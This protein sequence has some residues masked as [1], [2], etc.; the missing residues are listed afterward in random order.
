VKCEKSEKCE[1]IS[2]REAA[3]I[4]GVGQQRIR[5]H[6]QRKKGTFSKVG[7]AEKES[8][9]NWSYYVYR[10]KVQSLISGLR[11]D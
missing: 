8:E 11:G 7:Y 4:L 9:K 2:V 10:D 5:M 1:R 6:L 3:E